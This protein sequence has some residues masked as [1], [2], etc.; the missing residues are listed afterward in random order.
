MFSTMNSNKMFFM[1]TLF[2]STLISISSNSW[3]SCW[4]GL[5]I[6]LLSFIPLISSPKN[7]MSTE[8]SLKYFLTQSIASINFLFSILLKMMLF[9][10]F[11]TNN[12]ISI[13]INSSLLMK[14]GSTPFFFWFPNIME[15]LNWMNCFIVMTWQKISPMILLSYYMNNFFI[16]IIMSF[17]VIIG[18]VGSF[19]QTS[20]R[21]LMAFSSINNLGWLMASLMISENIWMMYFFLYTFMN[22]ILCFFFH[23]LNIFYINQIFNLNLISLIKIFMFINF[24]S[25]GG[26]P[27]FLGF[28]PKWIIINFLIQNNM[29]I[30]NLT[31]IMT[32]LIML[33]SYIRIIYLSLMLNFFKLKWFKIKIKN[34]FFLIINFFSLISLSGLIFNTFLFF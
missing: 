32:S 24:F 21:K 7:L 10:N 31:F 8:A 29:F 30:M 15:G 4:I 16:M 23:M 14:M 3:L 9:K 6:N 13:M 26:L 19:N 28:F 12:I 2:F 17:N 33:F 22:S 18:S 20:I 5:E 11:E 27:P 1:F 25:L 34:N